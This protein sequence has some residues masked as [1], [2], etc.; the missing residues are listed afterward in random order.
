MTDYT[1]K[2]KKG[3]TLLPEQ[4]EIVEALLNND[5][6]F[7]C[8]QTGLGKTI[9]TITA[10][11]HK[12][13]A[14]GNEDMHFVLLV[15]NSAVKAFVDVLSRNLG[16]PY[17]I[18]SATTT[19]SSKGARFHIFNYSTL[20]TTLR[21][22]SNID[23]NQYFQRLKD[24]YKDH[25]KLWLIAD[26]AH[27]LQD[28]NTYQYSLV[29]SIRHIFSGI[30][31][32]TAT[33]ILNDLDGFFYMTDLVRPNYFGNIYRFR[34]KYTIFEDISFWKTKYGK[35]IE[36]KKKNPI[37]FK[38]LDDLKVE[39]SKISIIRSRVYD[40]DFH[41]RETKLSK[42]MGEFY[43]LAAKGLFSG[44][45]KSGK[46][47]TKDKKRKVQENAAPRLHDLQRVVSNSHVEFKALDDSK[48]TEKELLLVK[49]IEE[50]INRDEAVLIYFSYLETLERVKYILNK[51]KEKYRIY[52]ILE[53]SG[54]IPQ[55]V[56]RTVESAINK[57]SVVLITSAGTESINLQ[58][59]N[60]LIFYEIPFALREF[61]QAS[62]RIT[63]MG[64]EYTKFNIYILEAEGTIDTYKKNRIMANS[65]AIK[66]VLG[67][68]NVLPTEVLILSSE[69][70]KAMKE[71]Y[72][73]WK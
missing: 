22:K 49:T 8:A 17:S 53:V 65:S 61:I 1:L 21:D 14:V 23:K 39:F 19:R 46:G 11:V 66:A 67:G 12:A 72:L 48:I 59:S 25:D 15:P 10:A 29:R 63:R 9:T 4:N 70:R 69:D 43:R 37:G 40:I 41:Y 16:V 44:T 24:L 20:S 54:G 45:V 2:N 60:N 7:N 31:F 32:L 34:N 13:T 62:G 71:E 33:P 27:M 64:S 30:W 51:I 47:R 68:S 55:A 56:R 6:F 58:R 52:N 26:E 38:N 28:P 36:V 3:M 35:K 57:R 73:W 50:V 5:Y 42:Y 18:Y